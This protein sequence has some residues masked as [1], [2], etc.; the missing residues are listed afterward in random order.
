MSDADVID[1]EVAADDTISFS[2]IGYERRR[3]TWDDADMQDVAGRTVV[4]SGGTAGVGLGASTSLAALGAHVVMLGRSADRGEAAVKEVVAATGNQRV[5]W[6]R[7]DLSSLESVRATAAE[8]LERLPRIHVLINN[9]GGMWDEWETSVDGIEMSWATNIVGPYLLTELLLD[10]LAESAPARIVEMTSGGAYSQR[11]TLGELRGEA[12]AFDPK[13]TYSRT[14]RAQIVLTELRAAEL[15]DRGIV[16]HVT[17]PGW[18]DS[19]G[20]RESGAMQGFIRRF[21]SDFRTPEQGADTAVWLSSAREP[22]AT[23]G[24]FWHDRRPRETHR[25]DATRETEQDRRELVELLRR[26]TGLA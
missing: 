25:V 12:D 17:H 9:A 16:V 6:V 24:L 22:G 2:R 3:P 23:S 7:L 21:E 4:V 10:R 19:P 26:L 1:A 11:L 20:L 8:L 14:K 5:E 13:A 15:A 18:T